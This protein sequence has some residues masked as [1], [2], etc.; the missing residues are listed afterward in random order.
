MRA[1]VTFGYPLLLA[2][3]VPGHL[4]P[5]DVVGSEECSDC[6]AYTMDGHETCPKDMTCFVI[7]NETRRFCV[8]K[9]NVLKSY[10]KCEMM[11][12]TPLNSDVASGE[13]QVKVPALKL[14]LAGEPYKPEKAAKLSN[15]D[16]ICPTD[17]ENGV[18]II[19]DAPLGTGSVTFAVGDNVSYSSEN[20]VPYSIAGNYGDGIPASPVK[21]EYK[22]GPVQVSCITD[23]GQKVTVSLSVGCNDEIIDAA[24]ENELTSSTIIVPSAIILGE[25]K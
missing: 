18:S 20:S 10:R 9:R 7:P 24:N 5:L 19:C 16:L 25:V 23:L 11:T 13:V 14:V 22:E 4:I 15:G 17:N 3:I 12:D 1:F 6:T 21:C 8:R 2:T